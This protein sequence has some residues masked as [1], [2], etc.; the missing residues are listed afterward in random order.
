LVN[1]L[2]S[3]G[4]SLFAWYRIAIGLAMAGVVALGWIE[5]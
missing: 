1:Y 3:H 4:L 5:A 2:Q